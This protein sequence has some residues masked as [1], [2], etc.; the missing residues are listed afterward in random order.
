MNQKR[1]KERGR[2]R[3]VAYI[4]AL[5]E[6]VRMCMAIRRAATLGNRPN[7]TR[8]LVPSNSGFELRICGGGEG[9]RTLG[10]LDCQSSALPAELHP[11]RLCKTV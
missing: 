1:H 5:A 10:P 6:S 2:G 3:R 7:C 4:R 9:T 8:G 11:Q